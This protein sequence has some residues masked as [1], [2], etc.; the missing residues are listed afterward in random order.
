MN[1]AQLI[2]P[3]WVQRGAPERHASMRPP[4]GQTRAPAEAKPAAKRGGG[5][6]PKRLLQ[7]LGILREG[8]RALSAKQLADELG[9][10]QTAASFNFSALKMRGCVRVVNATRPYFYAI[11]EAGEAML[12]EHEPEA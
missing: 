10:D 3:E 1:L 8:K 9:V 12:A 2:D 6:K 11:T 7:V 4:E 5:R